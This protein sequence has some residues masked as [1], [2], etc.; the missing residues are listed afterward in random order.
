M[1]HAER[2]LVSLRG[3]GT[4]DGHVDAPRRVLLGLARD[5]RGQ[6][7][8]R[9]TWARAVDEL[10]RGGFV[11]TSVVQAGRVKE[12]RYRLTAS[13]LEA[14]DRLMSQT[15]EPVVSRSRAGGEPLSSSSFSSSLGAEGNKKEE[16]EEPA[17]PVGEPDEEPV[18]G[19]DLR[20]A[21]EAM[22]EALR[23]QALTIQ[24]LYARIDA[25]DRCECGAPKK[26][27][28]NK[29]GE[30]FDGCSL[31]PNCPAK[32]AKTATTKEAKAKRDA[33]IAEADRRSAEDAKRKADEARARLKGP[34]GHG[35]EAS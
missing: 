26:T 20:R 16:E 1:T 18:T 21:V 8:H 15:R 27:F 24:L 10:R 5:E 31:Y 30:P 23:M 2:A 3:A 25:T 34:A 4:D 6:P 28:R 19:S 29:K 12:T 33:E 22:G 11:L 17:E 13:G 14:A 35:R 9:L 7:M 32:K